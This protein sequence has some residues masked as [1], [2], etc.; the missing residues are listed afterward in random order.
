[1]NAILL[2]DR[3]AVLIALVISMLVSWF[4]IPVV[5]K[6]SLIKR[7][8]DKPGGGRKI[9]KREIPTLGGV[10][11]Y[12]GFSFGFLLTVNGYM[13]GVNYFCLATLLL[14]LA[15]M[16][17]DLITL[18]PNKKLMI[19][20][21]AALLLLYFTDIRITSFHG[22]MGIY[23]IPAWL[24]YITTI[25][26]MIVII[27]AFN[28]IDGIDGLAASTGIIASV[29]FGLWFWL[30][31]L[32]GYA[33]MAASL[34]GTLGGFIWFNLSEGRN[35]IFMGDTGSLLVGFILA[36]LTIA[37]NEV[38]ESTGVFYEL[39]AA[40]AISIAILIV[41]LYDTLRVFTIR[42]AHGQHPFTADNRH[43]HYMML[44][45]G[46]SHKKSDVI[47]GIINIFIIALAFTLDRI[48]I[49]WLSSV[50]LTLCLVFTSLIYLRIYHRFLIHRVPVGIEDINT[51]RL[52]T[53]IHSFFSGRNIRMPVSQPKCKIVH[54]QGIPLKDQFITNKNQTSGIKMPI[55]SKEKEDSRSAI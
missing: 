7:L 40:P 50:T 8:T 10:A 46:F 53:K 38:S 52:I 36:S 35:K 28:L 34:I 43:I 20:V 19:E 49:F 16:K 27:N 6:V 45:A 21:V 14:F 12:A 41:P 39:S 15:G 48:G 37:F 18:D 29:V 32:T 51:I 11:L 5:V 23:G 13:T 4:A 22:F 2:N 3:T 31:G 24:S 1:M 30:S 47:I 25:F 42:L 26:L 17:D 55:S 33:I 54:G 9:H 44:R